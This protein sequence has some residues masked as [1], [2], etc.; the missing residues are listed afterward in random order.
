MITIEKEEIK[1]IPVLHIAEDKKLAEKLP[2][3]IFVHGFTSAKENNLHYAYLLAQKGFRVLLP[4]ALYHGE[5]NPGLSGHRLEI[6]FWEIVLQT[7]DELEIL[8]STFE[9]KQLID[10][11]RIGV[12]GTSM[13]GIVTLGAL[14]KYNWIKAATSLMGMP[15]YEK[16]ALHQINIM[17]EKG[18]ELPILE[19][20][21]SQLMAKIRELDLSLHLDKL[22]NRPLLFWHGKK[23]PVVP[24]AN[25]Y[26]FYET[27]KPLYK[28]EPNK[29]QFITDENA[30][31]KV[32]ND[33]VAKTVKWFETYI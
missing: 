7:I 21:L 30:G 13:G 26:H 31:H 2:F 28:Y 9:E 8:K 6:R 5:R 27:I 23:D 32:S 1:N 11:N 25:T 12:V 19:D 18:I 22:Q 4:E 14:T 17:K 20:E 3:I 24:Y 16:F 29:L 10:P 33:G 15:Y